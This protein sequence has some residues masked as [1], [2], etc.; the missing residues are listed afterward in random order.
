VNLL[1]YSQPHRQPTGVTMPWDVAIFVWRI[2]LRSELWKKR[3]VCA[4]PFKRRAREA[5]FCRE[6]QE[7][8][9]SA[10]MALKENYSDCV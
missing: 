6:N 10:G 9:G 2:S 8:P 3:P 7:Q 5:E 4:T 1:P